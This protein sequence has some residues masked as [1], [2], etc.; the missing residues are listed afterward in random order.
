MTM[1]AA[2]QWHWA[3]LPAA[4]STLNSVPPREPSLNA[5]FSWSF[6]PARME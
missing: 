3:F 5:A 2:R 4:A 6:L 1:Y